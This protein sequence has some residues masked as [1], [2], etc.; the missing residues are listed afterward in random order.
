MHNLEKFGV[1]R[2]ANEAGDVVQSH[3]AVQHSPH[4]PISL[5]PDEMKETRVTHL[6]K[7]AALQTTAVL[8]RRSL[9]LGASLGSALHTVLMPLKG[10]LH[11]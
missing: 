10:L 9:L 1:W 4:R 2:F 8:A 7:S 6:I 5:P 3:V 11:L